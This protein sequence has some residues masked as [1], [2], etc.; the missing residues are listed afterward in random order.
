MT[1]QTKAVFPIPGTNQQHVALLDR[2]ARQGNNVDALNWI[3][4]AESLDDQGR[5]EGE[6]VRLPVEVR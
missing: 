4:M 1:S 2:D 6:A 5:S 3:A